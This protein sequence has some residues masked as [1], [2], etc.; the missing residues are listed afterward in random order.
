M[1]GDRA[2]PRISGC[3]AVM[4]AARADGIQVAAHLEP[5]AGRS[6]AS[7]V[8]DVAY[9]RALGITTFYVYRAPDFPPP[10]GLRR[11][12]RCTRAACSLLAQTA[13]AGW[14]AAAGFDGL[15]TYDILTYGGDK[16]ARI[17]REAHA[18]HLLCAP[19]VGPGYVARR[20]DGDT[21]REA[22]PQR[23]ARTTR[24]GARR[25]RRSP[26]S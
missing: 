24:C 5:Y 16:F 18:M 2:Q 14:A 21:A 13:L 9:L 1:V 20:G 17:C 11:R 3:P 23:A 26:I 12:P 6:V 25:S 7:I 19:S 15:Y 4:A 8:A 10:T 22:P